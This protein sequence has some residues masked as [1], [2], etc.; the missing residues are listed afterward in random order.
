M[1]L[2]RRLLGSAEGVGIAVAALFAAAVLLLATLW[3][4]DVGVGDELDP[5]F[6]LG[7]LGPDR[8]VEQELAVQAPDMIG[9]QIAARAEGTI[10]PLNLR[11]DLLAGDTLV[12]TRILRVFPSTT[13]QLQRVA[14]D[15]A[16]RIGP[17]AVRLQAVPG[18]PGAVVYGATRDDQQPDGILRV[19]GQ[20]EFADQDLAMRVLFRRS[21]WMHVEALVGDLRAARAVAVLTLAALAAGLGLTAAA[22]TRALRPGEP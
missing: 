3:T 18:Q 6:E 10:E 8:V 2:V 17:V 13:L 11:A 19:D 12:A 16:A 4:V 1:S 15:R 14:F 22:A 9:L 7:P 5:N 20:V 21:L